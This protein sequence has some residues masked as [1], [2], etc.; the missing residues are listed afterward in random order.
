MLKD[1][2]FQWHSNKFA[3]YLKPENYKSH[4][5]R[6]YD[7]EEIREMYGTSGEVNSRGTSKINREKECEER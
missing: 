6:E 1:L 3:W 7:L 5:H 2:K 4:R